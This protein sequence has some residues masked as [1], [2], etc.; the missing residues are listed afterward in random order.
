M[1]DA[2]DHADLSVVGAALHLYGRLNDSANFPDAKLASFTATIV[3]T[4][5]VLR[6]WQ[7]DGETVE[8]MKL[9]VIHD[10]KSKYGS[11]D[12]APS[13]M[14]DFLGTPLTDGIAQAAKDS[15]GMK[16]RF[17]RMTYTN[18]SDEK[19]S[20]LVCL[21]VYPGQ[22]ARPVEAKTEAPKNEPSPEAKEIAAMVTAKE[23]DLREFAEKMTEELGTKFDPTRKAHYDAAVA[24]LS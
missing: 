23:W 11:D 3:G 24:E 14:T 18:A 21:E 7:K 22:T 4:E 10:L 9:K 2:F 19:S 16:A 8:R 5:D 1:S 15:I 13:I 17:T 6:S 20:D 12:E